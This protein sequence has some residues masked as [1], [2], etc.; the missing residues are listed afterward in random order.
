M[1]GIYTPLP[2]KPNIDLTYPSFNRHYYFYKYRTQSKVV[3]NGLQ[4]QLTE[5]YMRFARVADSIPSRKPKSS[6]F[7]IDPNKV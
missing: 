2:T 7:W 5:H 6:F 1:F 4:A 3:R